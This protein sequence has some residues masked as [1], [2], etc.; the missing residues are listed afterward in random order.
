V[1]PSV[2]ADYPRIRIEP[3]VNETAVA[4][5]N[6]TSS[7]VRFGPRPNGSSRSIMNVSNRFSIYSKLGIPLVPALEIRRCAV[8]DGDVQ[9]RRIS[10]KRGRE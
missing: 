5:A 6:E 3:R 9:D 1:S 8:S 2:R 4:I 10:G 7:D